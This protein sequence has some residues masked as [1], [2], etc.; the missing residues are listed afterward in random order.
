M[1]SRFSLINSFRKVY[2]ILRSHKQIQEYAFYMEIENLCNKG[3]RK[4]SEHTV[5]WVEIEKSFPD[6]SVYLFS[7]YTRAATKF[8]S[9]QID[10]TLH[11][12]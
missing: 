2:R 12:T 3:H 11:S 9:A 6:N 10:A 1:N 7:L 8:L 5:F 4:S